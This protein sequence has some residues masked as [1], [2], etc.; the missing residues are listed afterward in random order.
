MTEH[1]TPHSKAQLR[2]EL[3]AQRRA[4]T[5]YEQRQAAMHLCRNLITQPFFQTSQRLAVYLPNDGEISLRPLIYHAWRLGKQVYLPVLHPCQQGH[6]WFAQYTPRSE[7]ILNRFQIPEP[8]IRHS[9]QVPA[10]TLDTVFMP[11]VGFTEQGQRMGMGGG[12]YDRTF[13]FIHSGQRPRRPLLVGT[14]H[15]CQKRAKLETEQ[16]DIPMQWIA[17]DQTLYDAN[18]S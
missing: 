16:W 14:A 13:A 8:S 7:L 2:R 1:P 17:S 9:K 5:P 6:L 4:L 11:L 15:E 12:F 10:W 3:R 18:E